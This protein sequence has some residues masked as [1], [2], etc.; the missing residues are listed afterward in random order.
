MD[1]KAQRR[2]VK[3]GTGRGVA[4]L[5]WQTERIGGAMQFAQVPNASYEEELEDFD[6]MTLAQAL[7]DAIAASATGI[8]MVSLNEDRQ[9]VIQTGMDAETRDN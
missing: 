2:A 5:V 7:L 1:A 9:L 6:D 8:V 3:Q 4:K